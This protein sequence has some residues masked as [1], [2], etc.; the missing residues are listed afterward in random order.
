MRRDYDETPSYI[1]HCFNSDADNRRLVNVSWMVACMTPDEVQ[2]EKDSKI[3]EAI[4]ALVASYITSLVHSALSVRIASSITALDTL[5]QALRAAEIKPASIKLSETVRDSTEAVKSYATMLKEKG[6]SMVVEDDIKTFK[7][8]LNDLTAETKKQ[9][10]EIYDKSKTES[11]SSA[12]IKE[13]LG[14]IE[15]FGKNV[16]AKT[17]AFCETRVQQDEATRELWTYGGLKMTQ[18]H[19]MEDSR[20]R[21]KHVERNHRVYK[22][23]NCPSLGEPNC[24]CYLS[25]YIVKDN[26]SPDYTEKERGYEKPKIKIQDSRKPKTGIPAYNDVSVPGEIKTVKELAKAPDVIKEPMI[27]ETPKKKQL[28]YAPVKTVQE[29][30]KWLKNNTK[31]NHVEFSGVDPSV[32]NSMSESL[33]YHYNLVPKMQDRIQYFGTIEKQIDLDYEHRLKIYTQKLVNN[34]IDRNLAEQVAKN[35]VSRPASKTAYAHSMDA[36]VGG[37]DYTGIGVGKIY[38]SDPKRFVNMLKKDVTA[39]WHPQKCDTPKAVFDHEFGHVIDDI[40]G[41]S[42]NQKIKTLYDSLSDAK[43]K[44][45]LSGYASTNINEFIAEAW[46]E[47]INNPKPRTVSKDVGDFIMSKIKGGK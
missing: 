16:R 26:W 39:K 21:P 1:R 30:E 32:A 42:D 20:V 34:G 10:Q 46:M 6:G 12:K 19:T 38:G 17:A 13:E 45:S 23:D 4:A 15:H 43:M 3:D 36:T 2:T 5:N 31:L 24:R 9:L 37:G 47:Y 33:A 25:A 41:I 29:A 18:W 35:K 14:K 8:W 44:T 27:P 7:P 28:V 40:Y 11:W 22:I